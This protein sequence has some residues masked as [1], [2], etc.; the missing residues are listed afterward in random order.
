MSWEVRTMRS[1]TSYFNFTLLRKNFAR[2]WPIWSLYGLFWLAVLPLNILSNRIHWDGGMARSLPL[3]YLD[4]GPSAAVAL[5]AL[6]GLLCAMAVFSYLYASR[7]VGMLHALPLRRE[8]LFLTNYLSGLLFLLLPNLAVFLLALAAE[9]FAG[10]VVFS[11]LFTWLV[12]VSLFGL[13][14]YSFAVFCAMFTGHVLALPAFYVVLNGLA[15]GLCWVFSRMAEEFLFGFTSA[16]WLEKLGVWLTPVLLLSE[17]CH[18]QYDTITDAAGNSMLG[19]PYFAGLGY[20]S[21]YALIGLVL[22]GLALA[23]YRRRHLESAGD[24]VSVR[25]VRPVFKYGVAFCTAVTLSTVFYYV[26]DPLLPR[27]PWTLLVLMVVWGAAGCFVAEML[28]CKSFWVFRGAWKGCVVFL[29]CLTAA[30]CAMEF[31]ITG[32]EGRV[33]DVAEVQSAHLS[34]VESAPYDDLGYATLTLDTPEELEALTG[35]HQSIVAHKEELEEADW[36]STWSEDGSGLSIQSDGWTYVDISYTLM[37]G[38]YLTRKYRV[39]LS[40]SELD[41]PGTPAARLDALLNAPGLAGE[42][43]FHAQREGDRL[44]D[45][46]LTNPDTDSAI[47]PAS[48]LTGL[49][50]AVRADLAEGTLGRRYLLE[51]RDRLENCYYNDL[52]L[53]FRPAGR[54]GGE[55]E[56]GYTVCITLQS[57]ARHTLA[58]LQACGLDGTLVT[59]AQIQKED[60]VYAQSTTGRG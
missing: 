53:E 52:Y 3:N 48:A 9:V 36:E 28:L 31:D 47:V 34:G 35:L 1:A 22:A 10:T 40:Q 19:D 6:F 49:E 27:G 42:S 51:N 17:A 59:Q 13:F 39:P 23:A 25:W 46:W 45:A 16:A 43:Y 5:T 2:F 32:F 18:V 26:L 15:A 24:V 21:L 30:M 4:G 14:F 20:A 44:V 12:V 7:S 33:P 8:G 55:E 29:C 11:S 54:T 56:D 41:T 60:A 37:D 38:S 50:E 58:V 57:G